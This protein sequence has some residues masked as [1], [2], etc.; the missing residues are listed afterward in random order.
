M[1]SARIAFRETSKAGGAANV[2]AQRGIGKAVE[3]S[4]RPHRDMPALIGLAYACRLLHGL[5]NA[6]DL[7][8]PMVNARFDF[9]ARRT[10]VR[11]EG[12]HIGIDLN[13]IA[14]LGAIKSEQ[15][16]LPSAPRLTPAN[17]DLADV[18]KL[19]TRDVS[20]EQAAGFETRSSQITQTCPSPDS[21]TLI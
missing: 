21:H 8:G 14:A 18:D 1:S 3:H 7:P 5:E 20:L 11:G 10:S 2:S 6:A 9:D 12:Q 13:Y 15:Q 16:P 17:F 19:D 4:L